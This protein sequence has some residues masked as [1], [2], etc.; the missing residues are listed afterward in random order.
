L[1]S[2]KGPTGRVAKLE[3]QPEI[4]RIFPDPATTNPENPKMSSPVL[5]EEA[6][7][8]LRTQ[9]AP[10]AENSIAILLVGPFDSRRGTLREIFAPPH[11]EIREAATYAEAVGMLNNPRI[12]VT[13]C[14]TEIAEGNWQV[15]LAD[16]QRR[17]N[18]PNFIVSSRLADERL[19][20]EVLNLGGY[21]VLVQ[22]F[23]RREVLRVTY[24]AW[25]AWRQKITVTDG[26]DTRRFERA[27]DAAA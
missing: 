14:D 11:W 6:V 26:G 8:D 18:P 2:R 3:R 19:W 20:A 25:L 10:A 22:P 15:L 7:P 1:V 21:D 16:L 23:D 13:I 4:R 17:A 12:A 9:S 24:M 5:S 27:S